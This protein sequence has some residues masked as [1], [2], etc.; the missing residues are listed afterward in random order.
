MY[1]VHHVRSWA[2]LER[3]RSCTQCVIK[4]RFKQI[5]LCRD[6]VLWVEFRF[7]FFVSTQI[8]ARRCLACL[9]S[10]L[11]HLPVAWKVI[12]LGLVV[13]LETSLPLDPA[14]CPTMLSQFRSAI[15]RARDGGRTCHWSR[16]PD[17]EL[18]VHRYCTTAAAK[19]HILSP[20]P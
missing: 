1:V 5:G 10:S 6:G 4:R 9:M 16:I 19:P 3:R 13:L 11:G 2:M 14:G 8:S 18:Y 20:V 12:L 7:E 17:P 15:M